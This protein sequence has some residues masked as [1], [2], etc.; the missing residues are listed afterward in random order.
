MTKNSVISLSESIPEI[1]N[2][3]NDKDREKV[4]INTRIVEFKKNQVIYD[5]EEIPQDLMCLCRGKVKIYKDGVGGRSQIIRMIRPTQYFGYRAYFAKEP[6]VTAAAA[7]EPSTVCFIPM[8]IIESL[9]VNNAKLGLFFI[10]ELSTDLGIADERV[11]NLTQ[12]H[13]RGRLAE[14]LLFLM[15]NYGLEEDGVT[16]SIYLSREDLANLSNMTTSNAIRTLSNF[17]DEHLIALD[18]RKIKIRD[19]ETLRKISRIG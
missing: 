14:S 1:W 12:K 3:L 2:L 10:R 7:F 11:V 13:I 18:G 15:D 6:Y 19:A 16:I 8:N 4:T 5:E 9:V 17:V